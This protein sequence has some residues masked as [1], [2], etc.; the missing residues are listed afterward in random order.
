MDR[1]DH[2]VRQRLIF[3][4]IAQSKGLTDLVVSEVISLEA[5]HEFHMFKEGFAGLANGLDQF[6]SRIVPLNNNG[7]ISLAGWNIREGS[8]HWSPAIASGGSV[9]KLPEIQF[10]QIGRHWQIHL[11]GKGGMQLPEAAE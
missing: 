6:G 10:K 4:S 1:L 3:T 2:L 11:L 7:K 5:I 9:K 8:E